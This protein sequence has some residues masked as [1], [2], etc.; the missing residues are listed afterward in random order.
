MQGTIQHSDIKDTPH[1]QQKGHLQ[2]THMK[3]E[4]NSLNSV[5]RAD[6]WNGSS[7]EKWG[8]HTNVV[9]VSAELQTVSDYITCLVCKDSFT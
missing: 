7:G 9:M 8:F 5:S 2:P 1:T 4:N 3:E 6:R